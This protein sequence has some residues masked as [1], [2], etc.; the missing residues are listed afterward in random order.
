MYHNYKYMTKRDFNIKC[1]LFYPFL[2]ILFSC[3]S[4]SVPV[5]YD[6]DKLV[7]SNEDMEVDYRIG[8]SIYYLKIRNL[9]DQEILLEA[10]RL[11]VV[12]PEN[13][14]RSLNAE[15]YTSLIPPGS[16]A[17]YKCHQKTFFHSDIDSP[18][19]F[20]KKKN[21]SLNETPVKLQSLTGS[22]IK[23]YIPYSIGGVE[24]SV[25]IRLPLPFLKDQ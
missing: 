24:K 14:A 16:Y 5:I 17:I 12:S 1:F 15:S 9:T 8:S 7:F 11:V 25:Y 10:E 2:L 3:A 21:E 19:L 23:I 18:F 22:I 4:M 13:E 20:R 6:T